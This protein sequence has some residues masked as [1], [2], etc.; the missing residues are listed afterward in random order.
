M[1][2]IP[3]VSVVIPAYGCARTIPHVLEALFAQTVQPLQIIVVNDRSPD[4][5][6]EAVAP[7]VS[8]IDYVRNERNLG[9]ARTC[10][11]G[12]RRTT[13]P[14]VM[15]LHS[16]CL[17]DPDYIE[18]MLGHLESDPSIAVATGQY[19]FD[20]Y[21]AL[22]LSDRLFAALNLLPIETNRDDT[23]I[24]PLGFIEGKADVFRREVIAGYGFFTENLSLTAED[25]DLSAKL[26]RDGHRIVQDCRARFRVMFTGTSDSIRKVLR[27]Q[28]TYGRGQAY[29]VIKYGLGVFGETTPNRRNRALHRLGQLVFAAGYLAALAFWLL[30]PTQPWPLVGWCALRLMYY[31]IVGWVQS[32]RDTLLVTFI[33]PLADLWYLAGAAE[34]T[35]KTL[36]FGRT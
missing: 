24:Y 36:L 6:D 21:R 11:A 12:L 8:R 20:D 2:A 9:L 26:R 7:F 22:G 28:R 35:V 4:N 13:A 30:V 5:L 17:L 3:K 33:G 27:K 32:P 34:G 14:Y 10:N 23:G 29:V 16:D 19:L 1:T 31:A 25:Q 15:T 18:R